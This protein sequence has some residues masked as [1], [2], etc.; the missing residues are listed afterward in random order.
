MIPETTSGI[1]VADRPIT[2]IT[3]SSGLP[4]LS[5]AINAT[6][7]PERHHHHERHRRELQ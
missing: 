7:D 1:T 3:R 2:L 6:E 4:T 5:A